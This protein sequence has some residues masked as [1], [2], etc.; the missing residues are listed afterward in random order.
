MLLYNWN[1]QHE[2]SLGKASSR[3]DLD[4]LTHIPS[5]PQPSESCNI[6]DA[7][8]SVW[9]SF[10]GFITDQRRV[11][12]TTSTFIF[13]DSGTSGNATDSVTV[14]HVKDATAFAYGLLFFPVKNRL[15]V[16]NKFPCLKIK[17]SKPTSKFPDCNFLPRIDS[18]QGDQCRERSVS[19]ETATCFLL[20]SKN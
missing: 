3:T 7:N 16:C 20:P 13:P 1:L 5:S 6:Y 2:D 15:T 14:D 17:V 18:D 4:I 10:C 8:F 9:G 19:S 11:I 12:C